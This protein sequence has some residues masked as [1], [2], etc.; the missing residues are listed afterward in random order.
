[1]PDLPTD[2]PPRAPKPTAP[3]PR[4]DGNGHAPEEESP[5]SPVRKTGNRRRR[6]AQL[7]RRA[8]LV[9]LALV[10]VGGI[11]WAAMP[12]PVPVDAGEVIRG[13]LRVVVREDG[14]TRVIDR[15]V[16]SAPQGGH[17]Q[18]ITLRPG[19]RVEQGEVVARVAPLAPP[20]LDVRTR[21]EAEARVA[22]AEASVAQA[23]A[24]LQRA[25]VALQQARTDAE[26]LD[27]LVDQDAVARADAEE[28][29]FLVEARQAE[30]AAARSAIRVAENERRVAQAALERFEDP[31]ANAWM[32][33]VAPTS[34]EVLFIHRE[35]AGAVAAGEPLL[36]VGDARR[37]EV[38]VDVLTTEAVEIAPGAPAELYRWGGD[39][40]LAGRVRR[41]EPGAFTSLSPLGVEEQ[42]VNVVIDFAG[43]EE[44]LPA[45]GDRFRVEA[46]IVVWER[47]DVL[48]APAGAVFRD[49]EGWAS[50]VV[51][52][53][54]AHLRAVEPGRRGEHEVEIRRGLEADESV[55]LYPP[56]RLRDGTRVSIR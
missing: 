8:L 49:G 17:L 38:V 1:M 53:G 30:V 31:E 40:P 11:V 37:L 21:A 45:L 3:P 51:E 55:V 29:W 28:A 47:D 42:R 15:F 25:T 56:E 36:D 50:F 54:R 24:S 27:R 23:R 10:I 34:G 4:L 18:R 39:R 44:E 41:V 6:R 12:S 46:G 19:D 33:V 7:L 43:P 9:L 5:P 35:S 26:R 32:D 13:P 22:A 16:V 52:D 48:K 20:I 2:Q 14:F